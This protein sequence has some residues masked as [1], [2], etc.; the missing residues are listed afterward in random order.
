MVKKSKQ[1]SKMKVMV[2]VKSKTHHTLI[3]EEKQL[4]ATNI[5]HQN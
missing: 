1:V 3:T 5:N 4:N 2:K